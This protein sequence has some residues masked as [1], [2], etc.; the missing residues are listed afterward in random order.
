MKTKHSKV[1][2]WGVPGGC[3]G[4]MVS[5][6]VSNRLAMQKGKGDLWGRPKLDGETA[7]YLLR[8]QTSSALPFSSGHT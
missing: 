1:V 3:L 5:V 6:N 8:R 2:C 7:S 4:W